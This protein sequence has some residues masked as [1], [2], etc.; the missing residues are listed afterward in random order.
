MLPGLAQ[1]HDTYTAS[2]DVLVSLLP[3]FPE[4]AQAYLQEGIIKGWI[5]DGED[6]LFNTIEATPVRLT[7]EYPPK[8]T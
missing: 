8:L 6:S 2:L 4:P 5:M 7:V 1:I 3:R